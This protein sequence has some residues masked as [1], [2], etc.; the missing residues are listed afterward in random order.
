[1][2]MVEEIIEV[3]PDKL[4]TPPGPGGRA[5]VQLIE[6][7]GSGVPLLSLR[8]VLAPSGVSREVSRKA[9]IVR[10]NDRPFAFG[11]DRMLGQQEVVVRPLEDP[12]VKVRG[13]TGATDL[14]DGK[15]TLVLDLLG[16]IGVASRTPQARA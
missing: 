11:I 14:G 16:L 4:V 6:R 1:V 10:Q 12:L 13:V 2:S 7:R 9:L 15:P 3:D 8:S 5:P